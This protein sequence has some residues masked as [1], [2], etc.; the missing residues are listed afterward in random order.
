MCPFCRRKAEGLCRRCSKR[1]VFDKIHGLYRLKM[2]ARVR[3]KGQM[4]LTRTCRR[5]F[6]DLRVLQEVAFLDLVSDKGA[7]LRY[8]IAVPEFRILIEYHGCTKFA[9]FIH[10]TLARWNRAKLHDDLKKSYAKENEWAFVC[11][12]HRDKIGDESLVKR[13]IAR[14]A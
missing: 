9:K 7:L 4:K 10:R 6:P 13:R 11:F 8:D 3:H 14:Y 1:W 12:T 5:I 2:R